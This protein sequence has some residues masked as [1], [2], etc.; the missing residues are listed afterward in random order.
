M[1]APTTRSALGDCTPLLGF[2]G[3]AGQVY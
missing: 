3:G 2:R 1:M